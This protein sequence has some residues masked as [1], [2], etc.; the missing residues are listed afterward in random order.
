MG[1]SQ[2]GGCD[3]NQ[4]TQGRSNEE[5]MKLVDT[6]AKQLPNGF[7]VDRT[8]IPE[9]SLVQLARRSNSFVLR[10]GL[11]ELYRAG[12]FGKHDVVRGYAWTLAAWSC[13]N[14]SYDEKFKLAEIQQYYEF[15]LSIDEQEKAIQIS[16]QALPKGKP[17]G[18]VVGTPFNAGW[19]GWEDDP[20]PARPGARDFKVNFVQWL[21]D[22]CFSD[23]EISDILARCPQSDGPTR[24][25]M[26]EHLANEWLA[27]K[28]ATLA[29]AVNAI[30][31]ER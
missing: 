3:M 12:Y 5:L 20:I 29:D 26:I 24:M 7:P 22:G 10:H 17:C 9:D 30:H 28:K 18:Y 25:E 19:W 11:S 27:R 8:C 15:F 1:N 14:A 6:L 4:D 31:P 2:N 16:S 23:A 13:K 21:M